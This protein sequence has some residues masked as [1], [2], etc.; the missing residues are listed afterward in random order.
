[1]IAA[2]DIIGATGQHHPLCYPLAYEQAGKKSTLELDAPGLV[3]RQRYG[4]TSADFIN[5]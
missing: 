4:K 1:M 3:D 5:N 2:S